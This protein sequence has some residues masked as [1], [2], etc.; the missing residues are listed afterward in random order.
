M[1]PLSYTY[2]SSRFFEDDG[3]MPHSPGSS[4]P[5][6]YDVVLAGRHRRASASH[7]QHL[8][9]PILTAFRDTQHGSQTQDHLV[10]VP[11]P[12]GG[13]PPGYRPGSP[14]VPL[15]F[16]PSPQPVSLLLQQASAHPVPQPLPIHT[17]ADPG[18]AV[19]GQQLTPV[20]TTTSTSASTPTAAD[21]TG[22]WWTPEQDRLLLLRRD[23][24]NSLSDMS[25]VLEEVFQ[26][27]SDAD[28]IAKR[29]KHLR[30][31]SKVWGEDKLKQAAQKV[32]QQ[33]NSVLEDQ[34]TQTRTVP[35][36]AS[37]NCSP[38]EDHVQLAG[39]RDAVQREL[40][41]MVRQGN[42]AG[43]MEQKL[44]DEQRENSAKFTATMR[45]TDRGREQ[46][47]ADGVVDE[48]G[49][50]TRGQVV[51]DYEIVRGCDWTES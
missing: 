7:P 36:A 27:K 38:A 1:S 23:E 26:V 49:D 3:H 45:L 35:S 6:P 16:P 29:L 20:A 47:R 33:L 43:D 46:E 2:N 34:L 13:Y 14:P 21:Y 37:L 8:S 10:Q 4:P 31:R 9:S 51:E 42:L 48:D 28:A 17:G 40:D 15:G 24:Y 18:A 44:L 30:A 11:Y 22:P 25:A 39:I 32:M 41:A 5:P 50:A 12:E 19:R